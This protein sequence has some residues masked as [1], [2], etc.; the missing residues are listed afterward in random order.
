MHS[1]NTLI[2]IQTL[3]PFTHEKRYMWSLCQQIEI[4]PLGH[5]GTPQQETRDH[6]RHCEIVSDVKREIY[7][8]DDVNR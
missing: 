7:N 2:I 6:D 4:V 3:Y 8:T 5:I 1:V